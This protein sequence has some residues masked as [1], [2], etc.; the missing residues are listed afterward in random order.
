M[1]GG[2]APPPA[3]IESEITSGV[4][5]SLYS[6]PSPSLCWGMTRPSG[7]LAKVLHPRLGSVR[8]RSQGHTLPPRTATPQPAPPLRFAGQ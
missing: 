7:P 8:T 1:A 6:Q 5:P 3:V 4:D 2:A